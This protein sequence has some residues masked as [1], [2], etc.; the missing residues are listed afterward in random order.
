MVSLAKGVAVKGNLYLMCDY[1]NKL[2]VFKNERYL[3]DFMES[4]WKYDSYQLPEKMPIQES[5]KSLEA[6]RKRAK[7]GDCIAYLE[8]YLGN[9]TMKVMAM[10]G[11]SLFQSKM[12]II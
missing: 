2:W 1:Q 8:H 7:D 5:K 9:V 4:P 12:K 6:I 11:R 3:M 10:L